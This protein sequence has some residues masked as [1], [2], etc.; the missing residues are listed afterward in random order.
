LKH[1]LQGHFDEDFIIHVMG[2]VKTGRST[3]DVIEKRYRLPKGTI[4]RWK[5]ETEERRDVK[6]IQHLT[7]VIEDLNKQRESLQRIVETLSAVPRSGNNDVEHGGS[8]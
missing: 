4:N 8:R 2:V 5:M 1:Y 3:E 7:L 6:I